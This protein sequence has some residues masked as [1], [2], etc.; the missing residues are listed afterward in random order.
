MAGSSLARIEARIRKIRGQQVMLDADLAQAYGVPTRVLNQA[1][2]RNQRRFPEDFA[3]QLDPEEYAA[4][5]SQTVIS[6][7]GRGGR[8]HAPWAFTEH[9]AIMAASVL[10]SSRAVQTSVFVVRAF[11]H[12]R[13][14]ARRN[15]GLAAQLAILERRVT[16]HDSRLEEVFAALRALIEPPSRPRRPIGFRSR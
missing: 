5:R 6:N 14:T 12:I 9:G 4:L 8:R 15:A 3:F 10:S 1:V 2:R 16:V 11:V 13:D 7:I